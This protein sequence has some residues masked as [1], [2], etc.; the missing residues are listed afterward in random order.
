MYGLW[1]GQGNVALRAVRFF[2]AINRWQIVAATVMIVAG[3][4]LG[5]YSLSHWPDR[6]TASAAFQGRSL[7]VPLE[8]AAPTSVSK[9]EAAS[10]AQYRP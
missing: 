7:T 3:I 2:E 6:P 4:D 1:K 9:P 10:G 5:I 8:D